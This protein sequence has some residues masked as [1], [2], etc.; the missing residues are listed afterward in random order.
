MDGGM[1]GAP[2]SS[3]AP[4]TRLCRA[5]RSGAAQL[6]LGRGPPVC[7]RL[8]RTEQRLQRRRQTPPGRGASPARAPISAPTRDGGIGRDATDTVRACVTAIS[9]R[10]HVG[11][12]ARLRVR[13]RVA[14]GC[15]R[16]LYQI[17]GNEEF[18]AL[19]AGLRLELR[20]E[21]GMR[22]RIGMRTQREQPS[23]IL[24]REEDRS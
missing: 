18:V 24:P 16:A 17:G 10:A 3:A 4:S 8:Q 11:V 22:T 19:G 15:G 20:V 6:Q 1:D 2:M 9:A 23:D 13:M 5:F 7:P 14:C 21:Q 12:R